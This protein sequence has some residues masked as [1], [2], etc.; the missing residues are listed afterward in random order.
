MA[1]G[2]GSVGARRR[3]LT[4]Q[5]LLILCLG[6]L[7]LVAVVPFIWL[8]FGALKSPQEV[9]QI[10]PTFFPTV[11]RF[12]NFV[13]VFTVPQMRTPLH[14]Y[15][16]NSLFV[17]AAHVVAVLFTSSLIGYVFAKFR[18]R[19]KKL[20]FWFIIS[21]MIVPFQ[22]TMIPGYLILSKL[23]L[24]DTLWGLIVPSM[25]DAF[26]IFLIQQFLFSIPDTLMDS[27]RMDG[28][29]EWLIYCRIVTP[30]LGASF[31][32]L[33]M[34]TFMSSWNSYLWPLIVLKSDRKRTLPIILYFFQSQQV[35]RLELIMAASILIIAP[36]MVVF[37][38]TQKWIVRGLAFSGLKE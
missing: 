3:R 7:G 4:Q 31:A 15:Y 17:A 25:V 36:M 14:I 6:C 38:A 18:F 13:R 29:S 23:G 19:G 8:I 16:A 1:K 5:A 9:R 2:L 35:Q 27:A 11:W 22:V 26:G 21:T 10:P 30:Q 12:D 28:A 33:G 37:L 32:T 34:L 24:I 20:M